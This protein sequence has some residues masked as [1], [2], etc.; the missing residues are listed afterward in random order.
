MERNHAQVLSL[1]LQ[2]FKNDG[3]LGIIREI[4]DTFYSEVQAFHT[5]TEETVRTG[6]A[7]AK[8]ASAYGGIKII[9]NFYNQI[10]SPKSITESTQ[11]HAIASMDRDRGNANFFSAQQFLVELRL[12]VLPNVKEL[13]NSD[14]V[15]K[16][17]TSITKTLIEILTAILEAADERDAFRRG[18]DVPLKRRPSHKVFS[19]ASDKLRQLTDKSIDK[20]LAQ[21]ALYRCMNNQ[22][23]ALEYCTYANGQD[24]PRRFPIPDYDR[25]KSRHSSVATPPHNQTG[26]AAGTNSNL[27]STSGVSSLQDQDASDAADGLFLLAQGGHRG[28]IDNTFVEVEEMDGDSILQGLM[29]PP[30]LPPPAPGVPDEAEVDTSDPM[31]MSLDLGLDFSNPVPVHAQP[32]VDIEQRQRGSGADASGRSA[33]ESGGNNSQ[34][35]YEEN[36]VSAQETVDDLNEERATIKQNLVERVLDILN[37]HDDVTFELSVL[38]SA[39]ALKDTDDRANREEIGNTLVEALISFTMEEDFRPSGKKIATYAHLLGICVQESN[40]FEAC[41][42]SLAKNME[43]LFSFIKVFPDQATE[44]PPI[45]IGPILLILEKILGEDVQPARV[46]WKPPTSEESAQE[47]N[48]DI[49]VAQEQIMPSA[50]KLELTETLLEIMPRIGKDEG[51]VLA[52]VRVLVILSRYREVASKLSDKR[53]IQRLF[54]MI[55]QLSGMTDQKLPGTFVLVLRHIM[56]DDEMIKQI[57]R[58]EIACVTLE[59]RP[60]RYTEISGYVR[61]MHH[62]VLRAPELF[63]EVTNE[64]IEITKYEKDQPV[65][66]LRFKPPSTAEKKDDSKTEVAE[67][68]SMVNDKDAVEGSSKF[69]RLTEDSAEEPDSKSKSAD[70]KAPVVEQP[71]GVVHYLLTELL[72]YKDVEDTEVGTLVPPVVAQGS[73]EGTTE[74]SSEPNGAS[75]GS[76]PPDSRSTDE[77]KK[78]EKLDFKPE[79][80]PIY[81]YRCFIL[82]CLTELLQSYNRAKVEF[83]NFSRKTDPKATTPSKPR[84]GILNYL[85]NDVIPVGTLN[86]E[87]T[88]AYRKK[89]NTSNWA[90]STLVALCLKT[91][92]TG[93]ESKPGSVDE[94]DQADLLFVRKFVLEHSLRAY[95]DASGSDEY[96]DVKYARLLDISDLFQRLLVGRMVTPMSGLSPP[97][98]VGPQKS[99]AKL[100][101]ERNF[102]A[103]LTSSIADVDLN[104]PG[105]KRAIKYILK[106]LKQLTQTAVHLSEDSS[107]SS[108]PDQTEEDEIS[109]ATS[110]SDIAHDREETPD[111][112]RNSTLGM[113]EPARDEDEES[114]S[115][116]SGDDEEMYDDEDEEVMEFEEEIN[117]DGDDVISDEDEDLDEAGPIEGLHGEP[118]MDVEVVIDGEE[119]DT[120]DDEDDDAEDDEEPSEDDSDDDDEMDDDNDIEILQEID[121]DDENASLAEGEEVDF[122]GQDDEDDELEVDGGDFDMEQQEAVDDAEG[123]VRELMQELEGSD[124]LPARLHG[125]N[126]ETADLQMDINADRYM[127]DVIHRGEEDEDEQDEEDDDPEDDIEQEEEMYQPDF[128]EDDEVHAVSD[129]PWAFD[130]DMDE[131]F[132]NDRHHHHH[133]HHH[134]ARHMPRRLAQS[135]G[136]F[137]N[138]TTSLRESMPLF[139]SHRPGAGVIRNT[140]D[141]THPLLQRRDRSGSSGLSLA[142][143]SAPSDGSAHLSDFWVHGMDFGGGHRGVAAESPVSFLNSIV[144]AISN[145]TSPL[146]PI[147]GVDGPLHLQIGGPGGG[148]AVSSRSG[149]LPDL[150]ALLGP[151][152]SRHP[153]PSRSDR[154]EMRSP[155]AI[156][157][158]EGTPQRWQ[159]EARLIWGS[160]M[161]DKAIR[162]INSLLRVLVPP[163]IEA[164]KRQEEEAKRL[165]EEEKK[166]EEIQFAKEK[167]E[168]ERQ[169]REKEEREAAER[170]SREAAAQ[171][172]AESEGHEVGPEGQSEPG[173]SVED[174]AMEGVEITPNGEIPS[175]PGHDSNAN[176]ENTTSESSQ[177][178]QR[179]VTRIG[180]REI[181]ITS[182]G[183]DLAYLDALP[184]ELRQEVLMSQIAIH[185][186]QAAAAGEAPSEISHEFLEALPAEIREELLQQEAQDRRRRE[187]EEAR[188]QQ[189]AAGGGPRAEDMDPASFLASLDPTLRQNVLAEQNEDIL[190]H[191]PAEIAAEARALGNPR[192][193][194]RFAGMPGRR[195][196][197]LARLLDP[198]AEVRQPSTTKR[199]PRKQAVQMLDRAGVATLLRLIFSSQQGSSLDSFKG[200]LRNISENRQTRGEVVSLLLSILQDGSFDVNAI[201]RSFTQLSLRAKQSTLQKTPQPLKRTVTGSIA[202]AAKSV[203][204]TP[205]TVVQQCLSTLAFLTQA[206]PHIPSFFLTEHDISSNVKSKASRKGKGKETKASKYPLNALLSLLDRKLIMES[207][208]CLEQ[209]ANLLQSVTHPLNILLKAH[210]ADQKEE[211]PKPAAETTENQE[212]QSS[213]GGD[214]PQAAPVSGAPEDTENRESAMAGVQVTESGQ[215]DGAQVPPPVTESAENKQDGTSDFAAEAPPKKARSLTPPVVPDENLRLVVGI[216]AARECSKTTFQQTVATISNLK[217]IPG[218]KEVFGKGLIDQAQDLAQSILDDLDELLPQIQSAGSGVDVHGLALTKFATASSHQSKLLRVLTAL[219]YLFGSKQAGAKANGSAE[220]DN[221]EKAGK[222]N[223]SEDDMLST[224]Y[225]NSTFGPLWDKL[226]ECLSAIRQGEGMLNIASILQPLIEALMVVCKNTALRDNALSKNAKEF[227]LASPAPESRMESL[228]FKFT[229]EHRKIL[230]DLVR[231]SP[232]LMM[233]TF[234]L[235]VKN[236]KVL[237]F[238]N[239]RSYFTRRLHARGVEYPRPPQPPLQLSVRRDQVFLDSFKG[240]SFKTGNEIKFGKLSIRFHGEEGVDAGGVTREWFQVLSRQMF[241]PDYAL[242]VPVASDRTTFHPNK[243]SKINEEHLLFFKF[244]GRIIGKALYEGRALDCHFSRAVYKR[245]LGRPV[246]PKDMETLDLDYYKSLLWML[247]NDI[248]EIIT[249]TF[250][251]ETDDF[252]VTEVVDLIENGRT[253]PVTEDNKQEYV[254]RVVEYYLTGSVQNQLEKF[255]EGKR[256]HLFHFRITKLTYMI[257]FHDIV[258]PDLISIFNEQELELL[259]SGLP[260]IDVDDWKNH[261]EY[262]NYQ[263]SSP[264]IQWFWRAVR[265]FDKE[266][267]A[268]LLQFV[269][270]TSKVPLNG[271]GQLEGMNGFSRFN[272]HRDYGN[273]ERL[274][275]SHTCFNRE[276]PAVDNACVL[277]Y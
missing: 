155:L 99:I 2:N 115:G 43:S 261:T 143:R 251:I 266:E 199:A 133:H 194:H 58:S 44:H 47:D 216:I 171:A 29:P 119:D 177:P 160:S 79:Q 18:G 213:V 202:L 161:Q 236:P 274:P 159:E 180:D 270:G 95:K 253:I 54:L 219:D 235:L 221:K 70:V 246:S 19:I 127:D 173:A 77:P 271:F 129:S 242:F 100:M 135:L 30:P 17:S 91:N 23:L 111:L 48:S 170:A 193:I 87:E 97:T 106:P 24:A 102:I 245:I 82:Q 41:T 12:A 147:A 27:Q 255:L 3:G 109:S 130:P 39:A 6:D 203:E 207:S 220:G 63:V 126:A 71:S 34:K 256:A 72:A 165:K 230:N 184:E 117:R 210:N 167:E 139:R 212:T 10:T 172:E 214:L 174:G 187:R 136:A 154:D 73:N 32:Q 204:V 277:A 21:E 92:E 223:T 20:E 141:G 51:L 11:S 14:F 16:A 195:T 103:A 178:T 248:T 50:L 157:L 142:G 93:H 254:Q 38:I 198:R 7:A 239:K 233:G 226:S 90:I 188:R 244:I 144:A 208:A 273:K 169:A 229:E 227:A 145:G 267:R 179:I 64:M 88:I 137:P 183:I 1:L 74:T 205:L 262:H 89:M 56:E 140:D 68:L 176:A 260:D 49:A 259:I 35:D 196:P 215:E 66:S 114:R 263:A 197:G 201:E 98:E 81:I 268:K 162:I 186:S 151:R 158:P 252:G 121:G 275:S 258:S 104:F 138:G 247:E 84:S 185:R 57:M 131:G 150:Q 124:H 222:L 22:S 249:E 116:S 192:S 211:T 85:L 264:Q 78:N 125:L 46:S 76:A 110:V 55:K 108:L 31:Q 189:Q 232:K 60:G 123:A 190:A 96:A 146:G 45:W 168:A 234:S 37:V 65:P 191:L 94:D 128:D 33:S 52:I 15:E 120:D 112:F 42:D 152:R 25:E 153:E 122:H 276:C 209:L 113:F 67:Q 9:L 225:E 181:D 175:E 217:V 250:S 206:N 243:L 107:I 5:N 228:F 241:N 69:P 53:N 105:A 134:H 149:L 218:A 118:G 237:E 148:P 101:Y 257:G 8:L 4:L 163:A 231:H 132:V 240:L 83:I 13:W 200:I 61:Q 269:T 156:L 28:G 164:K 238:D 265:S 75:P 272:I 80:Y 26:G 59:Q 224:L 166:A 36:E 62:L 40:F 182:L 86:H